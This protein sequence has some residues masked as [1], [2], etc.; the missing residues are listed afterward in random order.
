[1][2][3]YAE[4]VFP[5]TAPG[6]LLSDITTKHKSSCAVG[7]CTRGYREYS[8]AVEHSESSVAF[9]VILLWQSFSPPVTLYTFTQY[10]MSGSAV[11]R[12]REKGGSQEMVIVVL[13]DI[14]LMKWRFITEC[15]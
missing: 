10:W 6:T 5:L 3:L 4:T 11:V 15:N 1:M 12:F 14:L 7:F 13:E 2:R 9:L 8:V